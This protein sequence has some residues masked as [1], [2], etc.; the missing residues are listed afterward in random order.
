MCCAGPGRS[1]LFGVGGHGAAGCS[2]GVISRVPGGAVHAPRMAVRLLWGRSVGFGERDQQ[3]RVGG[4]E[5]VSY[6]HA[7]PLAFCQG[8]SFQH[9]L[10]VAEVCACGLLSGRQ[11]SAVG[12]RLARP[13]RHQADFPAARCPGGRPP[14]FQ[15]A[16][17][18]RRISDAAPPVRGSGGGASARAKDSG[19]ESAWG[20]RPPRPS[21]RTCQPSRVRVMY[22]PQR[23]P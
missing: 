21:P 13:S 20:L 9:S 12:G 18:R 14:R 6:G 23:S 15:R 7:A 1:E 17:A 22:A 11:P 8:G 10:G 4:V 3:C 16:A 5:C 2:V 19:G